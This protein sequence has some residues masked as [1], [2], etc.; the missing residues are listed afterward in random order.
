M[1]AAA[2][3]AAEP[4]NSCGRRSCQGTGGGDLGVGAGACGGGCCWRPHVRPLS[5]S[6]LM[7]A[8]DAAAASVKVVEGWVG[9]SCFL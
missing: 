5:L 6:L 7:V 4:A 2:A 3:A 9:C 1:E 8:V